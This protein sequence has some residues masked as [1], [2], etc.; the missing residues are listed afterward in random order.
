VV[1]E[2]IRYTFS[3]DGTRI[4]WT[5]SGA[6]PLTVLQGANS[7]TDLRRDRENP[8]RRDLVRYLSERYRLIR[9]DHRGCGSS[10]RGVT[11]QGLAVWTEDLAA[12][13]EAACGNRPFVLLALSQ[14][15]AAAASFAAA[16]PERLSHLVLY[17]PAIRGMKTIGNGRRAAAADA[18]L[19][20]VRTGWGE[21]FPGPR[22]LASSLLV[23][24][25]TEEEARWSP[26][27][28]LQSVDEDDAWRFFAADAETDA[29]A[30]LPRIATPTLVIQPSHDRVVLPEWAREAAGAIPRAEYIEVDS[31]NHI[32]LGRDP[33][34]LRI[35]AAFDRFV[36][37][38]PAAEGAGSL[39]L[40]E[41]EILE[42]MSRGL[43]GD[44]IALE[45]SIAPKT[46]RNRMTGIFDKMG[47][48]SRTQAVAA[49]MRGAGS[50]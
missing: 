36:S 47:V 30:C 28:L 4:A 6:G 33:A 15:A 19:E 31:E 11:E 22:T 13:A 48:N 26:G 29:S 49:Y 25:P 37:P 45:L 41:R 40:R 50:G 8:L 43:N 10:Q 20:L 12:V 39:S 23:P 7:I 46:V 42:L 32:M 9:Y 38:A 16:C 35:L 14:A 24:D 27:H 5:E 21:R 44:A 34:F 3:R 18:F 2:R 1:E 17:A